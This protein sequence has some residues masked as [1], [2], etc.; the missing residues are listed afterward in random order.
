LKHN[1]VG[2]GA[3][4]PL[5]TGTDFWNRPYSVSAKLPRASIPTGLCGSLELWVDDIALIQAPSHIQAIYEKP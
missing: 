3:I 4:H 1:L 5:Q 2:R